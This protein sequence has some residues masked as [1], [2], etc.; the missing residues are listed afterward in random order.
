MGIFIKL[1]V[2]ENWRIV[3][4]S[5]W[6]VLQFYSNLSVWTLLQC[7]YYILITWSFLASGNFCRPLI[8]FA[9]S[10]D[11]DPN[12]GPGIESIFL[13]K[14]NRNQILENW[15]QVRE[16]NIYVGGNWDQVGKY[17]NQVREN[18]I[19]VGGNWDQV[20]KYWNQVRENNIYVG[21]NWDQVGKYWNQVRENNIYVGENWN[22]VGKY[23]NQVRENNIY[24]GGNWDQVG[25]YWNQVRENNIYVGENWNHVGKKTGIRSEKG[26]SGIR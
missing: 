21:G 16:N 1:L 17:W 12:V 14:I 3:F 18:N 15:N 2:L 4:R 25:K 20:G 26:R 8:T 13:E 23:W 10:L 9:N 22:Q 5:P 7:W 11:T 6:K 19:Y 24:V